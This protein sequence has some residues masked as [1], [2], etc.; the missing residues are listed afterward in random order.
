MSS[1]S[2][3]RVT[4]EHRPPV[5]IG[6]LNRGATNAIDPALVR[7]LAELVETAQSQ[8][9]VRAVVLTSTSLKFFSIGLDLPSLLGRP[10]PE[11]AAFVDA[12]SR[13]C[14]S[15]F[16]LTKPT[17]AAVPG[18]ATAGGCILALCCD[19]RYIADGRTLIG[20]NEVKLG[21]PIPFV[22]D[23]ILQSFLGPRAARDIT[24]EGAFHL[25]AQALSL[26][27]VDGVLPPADLL[28]FS[29]DKARRLGEL[30]GNALALIKASRIAPTLNTIE[31]QLE[32]R[33]REFVEAWYA[34]EAQRRLQEAATK[35]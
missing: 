19:Y 12:F 13:V 24:D 33:N 16:K 34:E 29:L 32:A 20:L 15:L 23:A 10:R 21:V 2:E 31:R 27:L 7:G 17:V 25:P 4:L 18:H 5:L 11:L 30:P 14:V 3:P 8:E 6:R 1:D 35:F 22:A 26:G 28:T 9:A